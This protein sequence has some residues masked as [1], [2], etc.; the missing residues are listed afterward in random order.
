[1][2]GDHPYFSV[3]LAPSATEAPRLF[4][5]WWLLTSLSCSTNRND[6]QQCLYPECLTSPEEKLDSHSN[7]SKIS[8][9]SEQRVRLRPASIR[10]NR[11]DAN[12]QMIKCSSFCVCVFVFTERTE[13]VPMG[14]IKNVVSEPI[15]DHED[16]HMMVTVLAATCISH[17]SITWKFLTQNAPRLTQTYTYAERGVIRSL[18]QLC[19]NWFH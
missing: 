5:V 2:K 9:G 15:E 10:W 14:S 16:Y 11:C 4:V 13:K 6:Y 1:M 17:L 12:A 3:C 19:C 18:L 7:W 8:C